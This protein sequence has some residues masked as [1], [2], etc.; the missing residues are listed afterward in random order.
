MKSKKLIWPLAILVAFL[1]VAAAVV[2]L[3]YL[4][5]E[6][7]SA[8]IEQRSQSPATQAAAAVLPT[9]VPERVEPTVVT[10]ITDA[11]TAEPETEL[12]AAPAA[13]QSSPAGNTIPPH[14]GAPPCGVH[15][16]QEYHG[17][18]NESIGCHYD[19]THNFDPSN[20]IFAEQAGVSA[21]TGI[22]Y[23][24]QTPNENEQKHNGY[25]YSYTTTDGC[26]QAND[27]ENCVMDS[28]IQI[29]AVG[30]QQGVTT[31]FHS[32]WS[33]SR[34]CTPDQ[35]QCGTIETGG[36]SDF[37]FLHCPYKTAHCPLSSD[38]TITAG[39]NPIGQPPY[40]ATVPLY[41]LERALSGGTIEQLWNSGSNPISRHIFPEQY[42]QLFEYDFS[43]IDAWGGVDPEDLT[44][45][46]L[47]CPEG[48]CSFNHSTLRVYEIVA[49]VPQALDTD[50][51]GLVSFHGFTDRRG[52][53]LEECS[54]L[55][56]DCIPLIIENAP[57]G[58][59][60]F[61]IPIG[62]RVP[63]SDWPDFDIYFDGETSGWIQYPN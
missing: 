54:E 63:L 14:P 62:N 52:S 25:K 41:Q 59:A 47:V 37:G 29:H 34:I 45:L 31:R 27:F 50:G 46:H 16:P 13:P 36:W 42:N 26:Q 23:P 61:R 10:P 53:I 8:V 57:V 44:R 17:L 55:G 18:W 3:S 49:R 2:S 21:G 33:I 43:S 48:D 19:H 32:F 60:S 28:L 9:R 40:L 11:P 24:W 38:P 30:S 12:D 58:N 4:V 7:L 15:N 56:P 5:S 6:S 51:D 22:S 1:G 39:V 20:T 35:Q